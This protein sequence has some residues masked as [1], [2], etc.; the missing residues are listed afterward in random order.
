MKIPM[1]SHGNCVTDLYKVGNISSCIK[2]SNISNYT[3]CEYA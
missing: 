3:N 2:K 1:D